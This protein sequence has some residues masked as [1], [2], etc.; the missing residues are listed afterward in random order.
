MARWAFAII[1]VLFVAGCSGSETA[2][3]KDEEKNFGG[4]KPPK[5]VLEKLNSTKG[6]PAGVPNSA[7][8]TTT[9]N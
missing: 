4:S 6:I 3:T 1:C 2:L 8:K 7:A 5:D 9:G